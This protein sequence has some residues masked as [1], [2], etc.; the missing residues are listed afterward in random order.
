MQ[1]KVGDTSSEVKN[2]A[3]APAPNPINILVKENPAVTTTDN[4]KAEPKAAIKLLIAVPIRP[5]ISKR[6]RPKRSI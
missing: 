4:P 1:T 3:G 6:F 5:E 2:Q